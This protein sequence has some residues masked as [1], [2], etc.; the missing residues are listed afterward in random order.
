MTTTAAVVKEEE[1][2]VDGE[3]KT[4]AEAPMGMS[5]K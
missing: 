5:K 2:D 3:T 4:V 1:R